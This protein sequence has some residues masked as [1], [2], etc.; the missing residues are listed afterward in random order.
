[1][2]LGLLVMKST[3]KS[4]NIL[5]KFSSDLF[6]SLLLRLLFVMK[7]TVDNLSC[8]KILQRPDVFSFEGLRYS[9]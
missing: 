9:A 7:S 8:I 3:L 6:F 5:S 4:F 2:E 1:M